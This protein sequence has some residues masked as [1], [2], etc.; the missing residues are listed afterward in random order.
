MPGVPQPDTWTE[1]RAA[2][3]G[4]C[5]WWL[6]AVREWAAH[7]ETGM[8]ACSHARTHART[9]APESSAGCVYVCACLVCF[10]VCVCVCVCLLSSQVVDKK[11]GLLYYWCRRTG[12]WADRWVGG[13]VGGRTGGSGWDGSGCTNRIARIGTRGLGGAHP[14]SLPFPSGPVP[15]GPLGWPRPGKWKCTVRHGRPLR[16]RNRRARLACLPKRRRAWWPFGCCAGETTAFGEPKPGPYGRKAQLDP[17]ELEE[18]TGQGVGARGG[19]GGG[20]GTARAG[21]ESGGGPSLMR[22]VTNPLVLGVSALALAGIAYENIF[23]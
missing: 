23:K 7:A 1:V 15:C 6:S 10:C 5:C 17:E 16:A 12:G 2:G 14:L 22:L 8:Q 9:H 18:A 11:T 3:H 19:S 20:A 21:R 4:A 13:Q